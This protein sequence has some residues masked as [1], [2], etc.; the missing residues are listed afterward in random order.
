M[1]AMNVSL[2]EVKRH[3]ER[4]LRR[5]L[6]GETFVI[7]QRDQPVAEIRPIDSVQRPRPFGLAAGYL[8]LPPGE[9][10]ELSSVAG[11]LGS[12]RGP[13]RPLARR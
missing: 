1:R 8:P 11:T 5:V 12:G 2:E 4:V 3:P 9:S 13:T 10:P 7:T 6:E